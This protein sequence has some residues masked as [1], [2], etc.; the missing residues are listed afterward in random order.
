MSTAKA[1]L[2][3]MRRFVDFAGGATVMAFLE[4]MDWTMDERRLDP[5][6]LPCLAQLPRAAELAERP[7]AALVRLLADG[8]KRLRWGQTYTAADF[9]RNF[10]DGYGWTEIFGTRGH[11][12]NDRI[13]GG[14]LL[15][16]PHLV[17]PDHHHTA[18]E[19]YIPLTGGAQWRM[20]EGGFA[21]R[22]AGAII[23]HPSGVSHAM[24]T[25]DEP[26]L[27]L[28]LWRGGPLDQRSVIGRSN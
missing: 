7:A 6:S 1:L 25:D 22:P 4:D 20:G 26:L 23:H 3:E 5:A 2:H 12:A 18:E 28:Y 15:L 9:G 10:L 13:A 19:I 21:V 16:A 27:A 14:F 11:F 17:Y 8:A 24:R